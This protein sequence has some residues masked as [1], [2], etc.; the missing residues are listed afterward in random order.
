MELIIIGLI[1]VEVVLVRL[2]FLCFIP[3]RSQ[4]VKSTLGFYPGRARTR[5]ALFWEACFRTTA[6]ETTYS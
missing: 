1:A 6:L 2:P 3:V 5:S 4:E